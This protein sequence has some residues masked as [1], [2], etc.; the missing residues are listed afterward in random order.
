MYLDV[1]EY[2]AKRAACDWP[3]LPHQPADPLKPFQF[4][5]LFVL[6]F[7]LFIHKTSFLPIHSGPSLTP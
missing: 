1:L 3:Q 2:G 7:F 4:R 5:L 6:L